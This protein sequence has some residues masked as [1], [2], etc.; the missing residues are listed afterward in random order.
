MPI[1]ATRAKAAKSSIRARIEHVF[2]HQKNRFGLFIRTIGIARAEA[3]PPLA[4]LPITSAASSSTKSALPRHDSTRNNGKSLYPA[5]QTV[6][7]SENPTKLTNSACQP[8][9]VAL[10]NSVLAGCPAL[11][12]HRHRAAPCRTIADGAKPPR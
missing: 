4:N 11:P 6:K 3:K 12:H 8:R 1:A 10:E 7:P 2:S 9:L 5:P